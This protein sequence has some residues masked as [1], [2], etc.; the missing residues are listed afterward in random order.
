M[1]RSDVYSLI[2][3]ASLAL[4]A[5]ALNA[6][7]PKDS[8][9]SQ[10]RIEVIAHVPLAGSAVTQLTAGTHWEKDY[11]YLDRGAGGPLTV[12]DVTNAAAPAA[13]GQLD[14]PAQ[15]A[16]GRVSAVVG[17]AALIVSTPAPAQPTAQTVSVMSFTDPEHPT[18]ARQFSGVTAMLTD[19]S[20][21]LIYLVNSEGLW[22][23]RTEPATDTELQKAYLHHV[24]YNP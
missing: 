11:L 2:L 15:E 7:G 12:L 4:G 18:V 6:A 8:A 3:S 1:R 19:H 16:N 9:P 23:L 13:A 5:P 22:V 17:N 20:R 10:D 21:G 24:L 14:V